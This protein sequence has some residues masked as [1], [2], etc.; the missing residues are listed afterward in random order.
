[1]LSKTAIIIRR[2]YLERVSKKSFLITTL[3][4]PVL[5]I[6]L[7]ATP[8][9]IAE[10][11]GKTQQT[12]L[13]IDQSGE[14]AGKLESTPALKFE[15]TQLDPDSARHTDSADGVL[16]I[17]SGIQSGNGSVTLFS[18]SP[19]SM[20]TEHEITSQ[21][22]RIVEQHKLESYDIANLDQIIRSIHSDIKIQ[23]I[24]NSDDDTDETSSTTLSYILGVAL[25]FALYMCLLLYG[26]MVMTSII[27]EKNNRVLELVV[28][29]V[30]PTQLMLGKICGIGLVAVT[31]I[32]LWGIV[33][34]M[35]STFMLP[36]LIPQSLTTD[37]ATLQSGGAT[38][39]LSN[40]IELVQAVSLLSN[41][42]YIMELFGVLIL[43]LIGGF[44][45]YAAIYAAIGSAVD[46]IQD[47]SQ[48]QSIATMPIIFGIIF[49]M[50]AAS[51]PSS[52]MAVWTSYIPFTSP[53]VMMSRIPFGL[54]WWEITISLIILYATFLV[55]VW[56]AGKIYRVGI[57][58]HGKK[59]TVKE[60][61]HWMRY[62]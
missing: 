3:L 52:P 53:M 2:E 34:S 22:D 31:Q 23:T 17:P 29:S 24:R 44:L 41:T 39:A 58:M 12:I 14:V 1:M 33:L 21:I 43:F 54:A 57:F 55:A 15:T 27:E 47:A 18:N 38:S 6:A 16:I 26:Q 30:K 35:L 11:T 50:T 49:A 36:A 48:L 19:A 62:K 32:L 10:F 42:A 37:I 51:D 4:M 5:M 45:L 13:V 8:A 59:P 40:D 7:M 25:T 9:L 46:N 28:S 60:L 61:I 20:S 56:G